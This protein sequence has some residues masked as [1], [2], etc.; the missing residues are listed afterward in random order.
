MKLKFKKDLDFQ[1]A[2]IEAVC[3][4]F[5][6]A[7]RE[8]ASIFSVEKNSLLT[9]L[10]GF[11]N[12]LN[13]D[14]ETI[15]ANMRAVRLKNGLP[16][17]ETLNGVANAAN[18]DALNDVATFESEENASALNDVAASETP[19][20]TG[21][22]ARSNRPA[23]QFTIEMET[24]TGKTYVYLRTILELRKRYG[25]SKFVIVVPSVAI[26]EGVFKTLEVTRDH[27]A[28]LYDNIP[29][30]YF[31]W[32][33]DRLNDARQFA[34]SNN[35]EI[36]I[37]NIDAFRKESNVVNMSQDRLS[38]ERPIDL[39]RGTNPIVII[40]EPQSVDSTEKAKDAIASLNP[41]FVLRY[42]ATH[43]EKPNLLYRLSPVDAWRRGLVKQIVVASSRA[44]SG[45]NKPF[46][47]L[48]CAEKASSGFK[49]KIEFDV[50]SKNGRVARKTA[51]L[52][53]GDDLFAKSGERELYRGW[54]IAGIDAGVG[55]ESVEFSN[56]ER[57]RVGE[58]VGDV[59]ELSLRRAQIRRTILTHFEKE[60]ELA[61][62]GVKVLSLFF[63][64]RV[65]KFR[66][67]NGEKGIYAQ[68]FEEEYR[69]AL[70]APG[71]ADLL[72][73]FGSD[74]CGVF[75]GY[76]AQ[77]KKG[78]FKDARE[79]GEAAEDAFRLIM[80]DKERLLSFDC[81]LRFI[82]SHSA[83]KEGWDNP[84]VFQICAL[85]D[86][87][88]DMT[89]RQKIGRGLRLCVDQNGDRVEAPGVNVLHVFATETFAEFA[90]SLQREIES[91][92]G[93]RFG[94]VDAA[95]FLGLRYV[96]DEET[97]TF[98]AND[99][100]SLVGELKRKGQI[101]ATGRPTSALKA[102]L[103]GDVAFET[104]ARFAPAGE[105]IVERIRQGVD[106]PI[107]DA[108]K[109]TKITF[110]KERT[111]SPEFLAIWERIK[112]K[113]VYRLNFETE[114][115]IENAARALRKRF[116]TSP[117]TPPKI[118]TTFADLR[119]DTSGVDAKERSFKLEREVDERV[120]I[121]NPLT[122][123]GALTA[124][125]RATVCDVLERSGRIGDFLSN[126]RRFVEIAAETILDERRKLAVDGIEYRK[127]SDKDCYALEIFDD[128]E[129]YASLEK[130]VAVEKSV[131]DRVRWDSEIEKRF[132]EALD[133]DPDVKLFFKLPRRFQIDTPIGKYNPDWAVYLDVDGAKK[134]YFVLETKG[135][136]KNDALRPTE[137]AK[138]DCGKA[139]FRALSDDGGDVAL[140]V[141]DDW[142]K[143]KRERAATFG[144]S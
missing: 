141:V 54:R 45:F 98:D 56:G 116:E 19:G 16:Q 126:P 32:D 64:D 131:Y 4:L 129:L 83:L 103:R 63:I 11:G 59:D 67:P 100:A 48:V 40:D 8:P 118:T 95:L 117:L 112:R 6:G 92:S 46:I 109:E 43:R 35:V 91:E 18:G 30:R 68:I 70:E 121:P 57:L 58:T 10:R 107:R 15:C 89:T 3:G 86:Q 77:D 38:G 143:F 123:I 84:N 115:L 124:V 114:T 93:V 7:R 90:D 23:R 96:V 142:T 13:I 12:A 39:I 135:N 27:F 9:G 97:R 41:W 62:R 81:P 74:V 37:V 120:L 76:F 69:R 71:N 88:S 61:K 85:L 52:R 87:K 101:D 133:A 44:E 99:A 108:A 127:L 140:E 72:K 36:M 138:I 60:R 21:T 128:A 82:F 49:A 125:K 132:A 2:A 136:P 139:H 22:T 144:E 80:K 79:T 24:G 1:T 31:V 20:E 65:D 104:S 106:L 14:E 47:R 29:Y 134:L 75:D 102:A 110:K 137:K 5:D 28:A 25:L 73:R 105:A 78:A 34:T 53:P 94:V 55:S 17:T 50:A 119:V 122:E 113:T 130:C 33:R 26:R 66:G 42:S 51:T 111:A